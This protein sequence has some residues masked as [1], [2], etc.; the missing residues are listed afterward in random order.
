VTTREISKLPGAVLLNCVH[1]RLHCGTPCRVSLGL[2]EGPRLAVVTRKM[3]LHLQI[4]RG[5]SRL[6]VEKVLHHTILQRPSWYVSIRSSS[7]ESGVA[8]STEFS[9]RAGV[10]VDVLGGVA[11]AARV[12]GGTGCDG[13]G[14]D[15]V[16]AEV[17]AGERG[18]EVSRGSGTRVDML[19]GRELAA[20]QA[21]SK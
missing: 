21:P 13:G 19:G 16:A 8:N 9:T 5:Q 12:H 14:E 2:C 10:G 7:W 4:V 6:V 15:L 11:I 20:P 17:V 18:A 1:L 3:Q